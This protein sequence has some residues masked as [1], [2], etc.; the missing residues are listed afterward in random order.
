MSPTPDFLI[1]R[2][3]LAK[4]LSISYQEDQD[5]HRIA[6]NDYSISFPT[7]VE[8]NGF[9]EPDHWIKTKHQGGKIHEPGMVA[10]LLAL[11]E[12][13]GEQRVV[14]FDV[15]AL[16]GYFSILSQSIFPIANTVCV[17]ANPRSCHAI[18]EILSK[19]PE[20]SDKITVKNT[21]LSKQTKGPV[22]ISCRVFLRLKST[23]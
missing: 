17:E 13:V 18:R 21:L 9:V 11:R 16:Y 4:S 23:P 1:R 2:N 19:L 22:V 5:F 15:G 14:F 20:L 7:N 6:V 3:Q 8:G 10:W 12:L